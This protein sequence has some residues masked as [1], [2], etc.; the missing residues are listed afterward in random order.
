MPASLSPTPATGPSPGM[1]AS[2]RTLMSAHT[3]PAGERVMATL[4]AD[5][6]VTL[7]W[8]DRADGT[9][10]TRWVPDL[11]LAGW[12]EASLE[13][14]ASGPPTETVE[15]ARLQMTGAVEVAVLCHDGETYL[16]DEETAADWLARGVVAQITAG[17]AHEAH[18]VPGE[19]TGLAD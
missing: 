12:T 3:G 7:R 6:T 17:V 4:S 15:V 9:D 1:S 16:L 14:E 18:E 11:V 5:A 19:P 10:I 13:A 2:S 8:A